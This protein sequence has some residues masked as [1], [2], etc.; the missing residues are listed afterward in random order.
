MGYVVFAVVLAAVAYL[1]FKRNGGSK[2]EPSQEDAKNSGVSVTVTQ[3]TPA[4][5]QQ[6]DRLE[7]QDVWQHMRA[8]VSTR[9][10]ELSRRLRIRFQDKDGQRTEREIDLKRFFADET[11]GVMWAFCHLRQAH[12]PFTLSQVSA[13][14]ELETGEAV[15]DL[16]AWLLAQYKGTPRGSADAFIN[17][18]EDALRAL[19]FVSKADR[20][21]RKSE[22]E[23]LAEFCK[24]VGEVSAEV[25]EVVVQDVSQWSVPTAIG[26]GKALR[27]LAGKPQEYRRRV[28]KTAKSIIDSDKATVEAE[29]KAIG[30]MAKEL[31]IADS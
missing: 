5:T 6:V 22:R 17:E 2:S 9:G 30:R 26:Y 10:W 21:L 31:G 7:P 25:A 16:P 28:L 29:V 20:A 23:H 27:A 8:S 14:I 1:V 18:H 15:N 11:G 13:A 24:N 12:R 19:F 4:P 3:S